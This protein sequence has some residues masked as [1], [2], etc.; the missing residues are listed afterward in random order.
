M[1]NNLVTPPGYSHAGGD[2]GESKNRVLGSDNE[3][4]INC[5]LKPTTNC[6]ATDSRNSY[7]WRAPNYSWDLLQAFGD[8]LNDI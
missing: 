3:I 1:G 2:F 4:G 7:L 5:N 8:V 6:I